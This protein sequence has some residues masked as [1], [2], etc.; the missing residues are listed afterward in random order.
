[1]SA[2]DVSIRFA[3]GFALAVLMIAVIASSGCAVTKVETPEWKFAR[4]SLFYSAEIPK[5]QKGDLTV[6]GY[7]GNAEAQALGEIIGSAVKAAG[8][9]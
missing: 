4:Y 7:K 3:I 9:K 2:R 5:I 1:M 8:V 6:E